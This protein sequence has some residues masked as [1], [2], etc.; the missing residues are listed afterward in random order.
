M[1]LTFHYLYQFKK[2]PYRIWIFC[3]SSIVILSEVELFIVCIQNYTVLYFKIKFVYKTNSIFSARQ[4]RSALF[5]F[6]QIC[7]PL[8]YFFNLCFKQFIFISGVTYVFLEKGSISD[9]NEYINTQIT[10]II[11]TPRDKDALYSRNGC[12]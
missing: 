5:F 8:S 10:D 9:G 4:G 3:L 7:N 2:N 1:F 12:D 6:F 11:C